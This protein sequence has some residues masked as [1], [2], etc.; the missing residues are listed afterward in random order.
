[1]RRRFDPPQLN[2]EPWRVLQLIR[3]L[4]ITNQEAARR[5][6]ISRASIQEKLAGRSDFHYLQVYFLTNELAKFERELKERQ[7]L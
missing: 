2:C 1:M 4:G 7:N 6:K 5:M 3:R